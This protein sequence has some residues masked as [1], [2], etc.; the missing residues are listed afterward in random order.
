MARKRRS[1]AARRRNNRLKALASLGAV[2]A[3]MFLAAYWRTVWPYLAAL[4]AASVVGVA[5]WT[6]WRRD[7]TARQQDRVWREQD[8]IA[9]GHRTLP[10]VDQMTGTQFEDMVAA[11]CRRDGCTK[12][13]RVGGAGDNGAD[14]KGFLPDGRSMIVQCKRYASRNAVPARE[15]RDLMGALQHHRAQ[16]GVFVTTSRFTRQALQLC[17]QHG[18]W[19]VH[20]DLLGMWNKGAPLSSFPV[21]GGAGQGDQRHRTR[22]KTTYE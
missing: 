22:W 2:V 3:G 6:L 5:G 8:A 12:V 1:A 9:A 10:E 7:R 17:E 19:A 18:I 16:V 11:L 15:I 13:I 21:V 4:S 14:V 20:R